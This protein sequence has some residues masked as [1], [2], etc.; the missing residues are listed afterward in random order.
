MTAADPHAAAF[1]YLDALALPA[2]Q[3]QLLAAKLTAAPAET[4]WQTLHATL[5]LGPESGGAETSQETRLQLALGSTAPSALIGHDSQGATRL[6]TTPPLAR[7]SMSP[8]P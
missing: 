7:A 1:A 6:I 8:T 3:R 2:A 5:A 4:V